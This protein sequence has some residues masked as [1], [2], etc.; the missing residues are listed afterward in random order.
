MSTLTARTL[1][2]VCGTFRQE[3]TENTLVHRP[4]AS[5]VAERLWSQYEGT[6]NI[7]DDTFTRMHEHRCRMMKCDYRYAFYHNS[8]LQSR[9]SYRTIAGSKHVHCTVSAVIS[10]CT[11]DTLCNE[12]SEECLCCM[13]VVNRTQLP[14]SSYALIVVCIHNCARA[15]LE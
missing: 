12:L 11:T 9:L 1:R 6:A 15:P 3:M 5:A 10:H 4:R 7:T 14:R 2:R 8:E 13:S